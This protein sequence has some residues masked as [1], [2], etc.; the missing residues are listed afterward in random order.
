MNIVELCTTRHLWDRLPHTT[1]LEG[2][3]RRERERERKRGMEG[4]EEYTLI[5]YICT[6][7]VSS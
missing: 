3:G 4:R 5:V 2:G 7:K 1:Y 6:V